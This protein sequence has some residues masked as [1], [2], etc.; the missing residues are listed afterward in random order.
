MR[1]VTV[2]RRGD[3]ELR[4]RARQQATVADLGADIN[5]TYFDVPRLRS[6]TSEYLNA[7]LTLQGSAVASDAFFA[8]HKH[9][10]IHLFQDL[11]SSPRAVGQPKIEN[12]QI[13]L[14]D[15]AGG[16]GQAGGHAVGKPI[17]DVAAHV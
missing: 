10:Y 14:V 6:M 11:A 2:R 15:Q 5:E 7:G 16:H 3:A 8:N 13:G 12:D 17:D 4:E 9:P 1:D